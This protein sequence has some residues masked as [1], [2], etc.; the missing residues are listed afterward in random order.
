MQT[1]IMA[2]LPQG[3]KDNAKVFHLAILCVVHPSWG[4]ARATRNVAC[5]RRIYAR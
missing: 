5:V 1:I 2:K 3:Q 4:N